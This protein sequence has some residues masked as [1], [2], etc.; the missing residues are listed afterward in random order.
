MNYILTHSITIL[1][2]PKA[3]KLHK[4]NNKTAFGFVAYEISGIAIKFMFSTCV[5]P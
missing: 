1:G 5:V 4:S 2:L 3:L